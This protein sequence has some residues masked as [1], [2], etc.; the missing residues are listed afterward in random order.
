MGLFDILKPKSPVE[1]QSKQLR[2]PY[3]QPEAREQAMQK[4]F[5]IGSEEAYDAVLQRFTFNA[6]GQTA[7]EQEKRELVRRLVQAGD[8]VVPALKRYIEQET[9]VSLALSAL[10]QILDGP[11]FVEFAT[12]TLQ[13]YEPQDHRSTQP[14]TALVVALA[15]V[16]PA[17]QAEI[18]C[19]YLDDHSDDTQFQTLVALEHLA[20][21]PT[22][23]R[24]VDVCCSDLHAPRIRRRA[25]QALAELQWSVKDRF[26]QFDGELRSE[27]QLG[28]KGNLI[29]KS[30]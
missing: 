19:P 6:S 3:A 12:Q 24:M 27:W 21:P 5:E 11:A 2:E 29:K 13:K 4:L 23:A 1:K 25:A 9:Q 18:L 14:K 8:D 26:D 10:Q 20:H 15:E 22:R 28:K 17:D 16:L 30:A 7:D